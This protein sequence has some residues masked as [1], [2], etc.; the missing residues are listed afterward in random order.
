M[1]VIWM[2]TIHRFGKG[3]QGPIMNNFTIQTHGLVVITLTFKP[4]QPS[5]HARQD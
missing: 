5:S 2:F 3:P 1:R 4:G